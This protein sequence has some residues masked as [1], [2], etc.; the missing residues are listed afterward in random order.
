M[1]LTPASSGGASITKSRRRQNSLLR[2][3]GFLSLISF[4]ALVTHG[5]ISADSSFAQTYSANASHRQGERL[6]DKTLGRLPQ[7]ESIYGSIPQ[8]LRQGLIEGLNRFLTFRREQRWDSLYELISRRDIR[9]RTI[10]QFVADYSKYPGVG[11]TRRKLLGFSPK[12][13]TADSTER[14]SW[15]VAGCAQLTGVRFPLDAFVIAS[16]ENERWHFSDVG[17]L[18]PTDTAFVPCGYPTTSA[19]NSRP[20]RVSVN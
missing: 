10:G 2:R 11:G 8:S 1:N 4:C 15:I 13:V 19:K 17:I 6:A 7:D 3:I 12:A 16:R 18:A 9:G 14:G 5:L 20:R